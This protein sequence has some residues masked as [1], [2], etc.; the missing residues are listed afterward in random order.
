MKAVESGQKHWKIP[1]TVTA[2]AKR[3]RGMGDGYDA[4]AVE[5][6]IGVACRVA[7]AQCGVP[8]TWRECDRG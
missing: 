2:T 8:S 6:G 3:I 1:G 7:G 4:L 5:G